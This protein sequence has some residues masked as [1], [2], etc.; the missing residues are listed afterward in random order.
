MTMTKRIIPQ[1]EFDALTCIQ[2]Q[3]KVK[4]VQT[5]MTRLYLYLC[6]KQSIM[7]D[8]RNAIKIEIFR[9]PL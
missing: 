6:H 5:I 3:K 4:C 1:K 8:H 9:E 2:S 7:C